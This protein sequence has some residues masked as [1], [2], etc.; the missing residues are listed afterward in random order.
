MQLKTLLQLSLLLLLPFAALQLNA[1]IQLK[2]SIYISKLLDE[3]QEVEKSDLKK[4]I[5]LAR[6]ALAKAQKG[7]YPTLMAHAYKILGR[8]NYLNGDWDLAVQQLDSAF[9]LASQARDTAILS[10]IYN[11]YG[12]IYNRQGKHN[13]ARDAFEQCVAFD[14]IR[15]D[16]SSLAVSYGNLATA[17]ERLGLLTE[18]KAYYLKSLQLDTTNI[19]HRVVTCGNIRNVYFLNGQ[20]DS[21]LW[22]A[23]EAVRM[24]PQI[25]HRPI[26]IFTR[27]QLGFTL[28]NVDNQ[29]MALELAR[30]IKNDLTSDKRDKRFWAMY[31]QLMRETY[32]TMPEARDSAAHYA[33]LT[34]QTCEPRDTNCILQSFATL[35]NLY[36]Q[37]DQIDSSNYY[38]TLAKDIA[39]RAQDVHFY[40]YSEA[41]AV[42]NLVK[43][44]RFEEALVLA[45]S[46]LRL[47][48]RENHAIAR[49]ELYSNLQAI[50]DSLGNTR[51]A[52]QYFRAY[53]DLKDSILSSKTYLTAQEI[54]TQQKITKSEEQFALRLAT[55]SASNRRVK[56]ISTGVIGVILLLLYL[57]WQY[58]KKR[59]GA[60]L[61]YLLSRLKSIGRPNEAP[62]PAN[63]LKSMGMLETIALS[64]ELQRLQSLVG[65]MDDKASSPESKA[66]INKLVQ[67]K[68]E[69]L[70]GLQFSIS[71]DLKRYVLNLQ[72]QLSELVSKNQP[73]SPNEVAPVQQTTGEMIA[74]MEQLKEIHRI[75]ELSVHT[76]FLNLK[77]LVA[78]ILEQLSPERNYPAAQ[79]EIHSDLPPVQTD[80]L[81][82]RQVITNL[83]ENA[84]KYSQHQSLPKVEIGFLSDATKP[85]LYIRD[86]GA[87]IP[88]NE[89]SKIFEP[90]YRSNLTQAPGSG[91]GLAISRIAAQKLGGELR[92]ESK[93]GEGSTFYFALS[94]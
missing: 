48:N 64:E 74:F 71:H 77:D 19:R 66:S 82:A 92:V 89:Q 22:Y 25:N 88:E 35:G 26:S 75:D 6:S 36:N 9:V 39:L 68:I 2:D 56:L 63:E 67:E 21:A 50:H 18:A 60:N 80:P 94:A 86:N 65:H 11:S 5:S 45:D 16:T 55:L 84:L 37:I 69:Y 87:G 4:S 29:E 54:S 3:A 57:T 91:L 44:K 70:E 20:L 43:E 27:V 78:D 62:L 24:S 47:S 34:L 53:A 73:L 15:K 41:I 61:R 49:I 46:I 52:Y 93:I 31:Y 38:L 30:E 8:D 1:Q 10:T 58:Y 14:Q 32:L 79:I 7:P 28:A 42:S 83:L 72:H 81:L 76:T 59:E 13:E 85:A 51:Q 23:K 40:T 12:T 90:F 33:H 17:L